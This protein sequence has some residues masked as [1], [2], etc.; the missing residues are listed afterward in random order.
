MF[1]KFNTARTAII[2]VLSVATLAGAAGS[3]AAQPSREH[4]GGVV[5][6]DAPGGRQEAGAVIGAIIGGVIGSNVARNERTAGTVVGAVVGAGVGSA[7][8]CQSQHERERRER[9]E[10]WND[11]GYNDGG[12]YPASYRPMNQWM[13]AEETV[14]VRSAPDGRSDRLATLREGQTFQAVGRVRGTDWIVVADEG[15]IVGYVPGDAVEPT[16][17]GQYAQLDD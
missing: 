3:A 15:R 4:L 14:A 16:S 9:R 11:N 6:C 2:A 12:V 10:A 7:I 8:G 1:S 17:Y 13:T 5:G